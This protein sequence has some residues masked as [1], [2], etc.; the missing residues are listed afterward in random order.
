[1]GVMFFSY[2][3]H[4]DLETVGPVAVKAGA[5]SAEVR[6]SAPIDV[7]PIGGWR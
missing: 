7:R 2:G 5:F 6:A 3:S 4:R 1:M